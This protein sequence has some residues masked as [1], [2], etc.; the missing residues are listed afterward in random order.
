V[1]EDD[2]FRRNDPSPGQQRS[3]SFGSRFDFK[4]GLGAATWI[5]YELVRKDGVL[6]IP[7]GA[8]RA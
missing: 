7:I 6:Q 8:L 3:G 2:P 5:G 4:A 1:A